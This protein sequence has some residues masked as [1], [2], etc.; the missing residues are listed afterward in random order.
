MSEDRLRAWMEANQLNWDD[1]TAVHLR[2]RT[3]F[4]PIDRVRA[5]DDAFG[6]PEDSELGDV[7][8]KRLI[9]LQCHFGLDT[10]R[11][12]RRGAAEWLHRVDPAQI[13]TRGEGRRGRAILVP[14]I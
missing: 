7:A 4:Y 10:I 5:G 8:G 3:S 11:L 12:A 13:S 2:N 6:E 1:R 9:H 14:P